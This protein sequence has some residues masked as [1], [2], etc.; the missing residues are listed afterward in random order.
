MSHQFI[1]ARQEFRFGE[2]LSLVSSQ[3]PTRAIEVGVGV[4]KVRFRAMVEVDVGGKRDN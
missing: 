3:V 1:G 4:E 2:A